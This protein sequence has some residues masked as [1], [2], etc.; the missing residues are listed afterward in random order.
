MNEG[1]LFGEREGWHLPGFN[2]AHWTARDLSQGLPGGGAGIGFFVTTFELAFPRESDGFVSFV[3]EDD[4]SQPYRALLF[5]NG[6]MFGK[7]S[8]GSQRSCGGGYRCE[9]GDSVWPILARKQNSRFLPG[10]WTFTERSECLTICK[11]ENDLVLTGLVCFS[12]VAVMLWA[13]EETPVSPNLKLVV[14]EVLDGGV[15]A[16][17]LNN[18]VWK[19]RSS[20]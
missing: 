13:L 2:T 19:R 8:A 14:D 1:G 7:V 10:F 11:N 20:G 3:F 9:R 12:T 16:I 6:W 4:D 17:T 15:G 5:V 18:P